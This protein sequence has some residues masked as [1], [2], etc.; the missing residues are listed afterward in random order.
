MVLHA[1]LLL[2]VHSSWLLVQ[3]H[4]TRLLMILH[5][6]SSLGPQGDPWLVVLLHA[7]LLLLHSRLLI[8]LH[9]DLWLVLDSAWPLLHAHLRGGVMLQAL[10]L[11]R[12]IVLRTLRHSSRMLVMLHRGRRMRRLLLMML[13]RSCVLLLLVLHFIRLSLSLRRL[14]LQTGLVHRILVL[15][16]LLLGVR[17]LLLPHGL[18]VLQHGRR[19]YSSGWLRRRS[20]CGGAS[21]ARIHS[22]SCASSNLL[23]HLAPQTPNMERRFQ[24][25]EVEWDVL[26]WV[27][28]AKLGAVQPPRAPRLHIP[29]SQCGAKARGVLSALVER[30]PGIHLNGA[31][32]AVVNHAHVHMRSARS[33]SASSPA[34]SRRRLL[35]YQIRH[36]SRTAAWPAGEPPAWCGCSDC[37]RS[38]AHTCTDRPQQLLQQSLQHDDVA[39]PIPTTPGARTPWHTHQHRPVTHRRG[40]SGSVAMAERSRGIVSSVPGAATAAAAAA[41]SFSR[42][43]SNSPRIAAAALL[44]GLSDELKRTQFATM[45]S[46][47]SA[48]W[49]QVRSLS[50]SVD[51]ICSLMVVRAMGCLI[52][53]LYALFCT[54]QRRGA[55]T[56]QALQQQE[57]PAH[58]A[59]QVRAH[60]EVRTMRELRGPFCGST[61]KVWSLSFLISLFTMLMSAF[62]VTIAS[63]GTSAARE[64]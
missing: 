38:T 43:R 48:I 62:S 8:L 58:G 25:T 64:S 59:T 11:R 27:R 6:T 19:L 44:I 15:Q 21:N 42:I 52:A 61:L 23:E 1:R 50:P 18:L 26:L 32:D 45:R 31:L 10:L 7:H 20:D 5:C 9:P 41:L 16:A 14:R 37:S 2:L 46:S 3:L 39:A 55:R 34:A 33:T 47:A 28:V 60:Q 12:G 63:S 53:A 36:R 40:G 30:R 22:L 4:R 49:S 57:I 13:R 56:F 17:Q 51:L 29:A 35:S 24:G 54:R